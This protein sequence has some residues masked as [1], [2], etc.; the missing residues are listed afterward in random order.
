MATPALYVLKPGLLTTV[1]DLGRIGYQHMG[2]AA[3]GALD[4]ISLRAANALV[5]NAPDTGAL[6]VAYV[7]PTLRVDADLV[8]MACVGGTATIE[9]LTNEDAEAG[10][11]IP[12][13]QSFFARRGEVVRIGAVCNAAVLYLAVAGGLAIQPV[14]GSVSTFVRGGI[15]GWQGRALAVG[16]MLPLPRNLTGDR[17]N[18][19]LEGFHLARPSRYRAILGPQNAYFSERAI[20]VFFNSEYTVQPATDRMAIHLSGPRLEHVAGFD[21]VSD[22]IALGSIQVPGNGQPILL[23]ADRQ[24]TG[25]YPKIATV[26][27]A[28]LPALGRVRIGEKIAF[29]EITIEEAQY[30]RGKLFAEIESIPQHIVPVGRNSEALTHHLLVSNLI[31]GAVDAHWP[32][33]GG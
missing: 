5:G 17:A 22:S 20:K 4:P 24:T 15:G 7:G 28:D 8:Q 14:L 1:Q 10:I 33:A 18:F 6:E 32:Q 12:G 27:Y 11:R 3:S 23:M 9:I 13:M 16:D 25:G 31:S 19:R 30:L 2:V 29:E 21:I 26:I